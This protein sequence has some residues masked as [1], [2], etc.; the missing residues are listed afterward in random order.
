MKAITVL[1]IDPNKRTIAALNLRAGGNLTP[2]LLRILRA[3]HIVSRKLMDHPTQRRLVRNRHAHI[4]GQPAMIDQ[5]PVGIMVV[6]GRDVEETD[7]G[8][9]IRGGEDTA[10]ISIVYGGGTDGEIMMDSPVKVA[11]LL[12][13]IQWLEGEDI[14]SVKERADEMLPGINPE[15]RDAL[16][17]AFMLPSG[18]M[19]ISADAKTAV[20]QAMQTLGLTTEMSDGQKLTQ[21]GVAVHDLIAAEEVGS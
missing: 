16:T 9:R 17:E 19:W 3:R 4:P 8:W 11:W 10:G 18:G 6:A 13:R 14:S 5:G 1:R 21:L 15:I 12:E 2:D 20:G 7:R